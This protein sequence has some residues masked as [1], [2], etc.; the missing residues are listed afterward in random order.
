MQDVKPVDCAHSLRV[1][2]KVRIGCRGDLISADAICARAGS[3]LT[4]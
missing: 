3:A 1:I 4:G 2:V